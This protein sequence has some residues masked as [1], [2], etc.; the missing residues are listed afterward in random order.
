VSSIGSTEVVSQWDELTKGRLQSNRNPCVIM[1]DKVTMGQVNLTLVPLYLH[2]VYSI[3]IE[4]EAGW[5]PKH[6]RTFWSGEKDIS[7]TWF[8]TSNSA[9]RRPVTI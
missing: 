4:Y 9:A 8:R 7:S 2:E 5:T 6:V 1:I 3:H